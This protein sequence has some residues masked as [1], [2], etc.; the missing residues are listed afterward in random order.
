MFSLLVETCRSSSLRVA[1]QAE[2]A[3]K[4]LARA[5]LVAAVE[6]R[7]SPMLPMR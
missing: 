1:A 2:A 6:V 3:D 4:M 7:S 5:V